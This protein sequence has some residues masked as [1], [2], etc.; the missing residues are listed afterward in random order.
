MNKNHNY[1][2]VLLFI[3]SGLYYWV[4]G[5]VQETPKIQKPKQDIVESV[6][7]K[8]LFVSNSFD[9]TSSVFN[10]SFN[11]DGVDFE[12]WHLQKPLLP[13]ARLLDFRMFG[14]RFWFSGNSGLISFNPTTGRWFLLDRE[15]GLPGDTAYG[16]ELDQDKLLLDIYNWSEKRSLSNAGRYHFRD[17]ELTATRVTRIRA[18]AAGILFPETK[19]ISRGVS[20]ILKLEGSTWFTYRGTQNKG[21]EKFLDGGVALKPTDGSPVTEFT[22]ADGLASSYCNSIAATSDG[23]VWVSHWHEELGLSRFDENQGSWE[24][25]VKSKNGIELGGV[26]IHSY[27]AFIFVAQQRGLVVYDTESGLA[28]LIE[29]EDG[30]PGYIVTDVQFTSHDSAWV[31]AYSYGQGGQKSAGLS[32]IEIDSLKRY[33]ETLSQ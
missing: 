17:D 26:S 25:I 32:K 2:L 14:N 24:V 5:S 9:I 4:D 23:A 1:I 18:K 13:N 29:E 12:S 3:F 33:F 19:V 21:E 8:P 27:E 22:T 10:K 7:S 6:D 15:H 30:L 20:D 28:I 31:S 11:V 16:I